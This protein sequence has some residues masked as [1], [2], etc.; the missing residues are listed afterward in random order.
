MIKVKP[1]RD[2]LLGAF[3][4]IPMI[5][6]WILPWGGELNLYLDIF[7]IAFYLPDCLY[8]VYLIEKNRQAKQFNI[9]SHSSSAILILL[10]SVMVCYCSIILALKNIP[11]AF[12]VIINNL[13][14]VWLSFVYLIYPLTPRQ[15]QSTRPLMVGA[16]LILVGEVILYG[17]GILYYN[18][19]SVHLQGQDYGGV[20]RIST[21][22]AA[23][24][25]TALIIGLL[26]ASCL[27]L[28]DWTATKK[29]ILICITSLGVFLTMS[30]GTSLVW[31]IFILFYCYKFFFSNYRGIK[32]FRS[33]L[34]LS[35][36][37]FV[38]YW[39]G[40]F[41]PLIARTEQMEESSDFT[42]GRNSKFDKSMK[43]IESSEPWGYGLAQVL[44][45]KAVEKDFRAPYHFAPHNM[46]TLIAIELGYPGILLFI[47]L[48]IFYISIISFKQPLSYYI[49]L[50]LLINANTESVIL[51]SEYA[52][53]LLFA[54]MGT[55]KRMAVKR[56]NLLFP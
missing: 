46:Y 2:F 53:L 41:N 39:A 4:V 54:I 13:S 52:S 33:L 29:I 5:S 49:I 12:N 31:G 21:T 45:E 28:Y 25:G 17:T 6:H 1:T 9:I 18:V 55:S 10:L 42:A 48:I 35:I 24:T 34:G 56:D 7:G 19:G 23:A 27:C 15:L 22:V 47:L 36:V 8:F 3:I 30:R 14:I 40:G 26:G 50:L 43:M 11:Y 44:P 51:D 16:L 20:M 38:F 32:K 37:V